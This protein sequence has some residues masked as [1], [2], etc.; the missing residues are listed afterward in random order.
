LAVRIHLSYPFAFGE[1]QERELDFLDRQFLRLN[2]SK[3]LNAIPLIIV[4][5][6]SCHLPQANG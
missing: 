3:Y 5:F 1:R 4:G 6:P 2:D